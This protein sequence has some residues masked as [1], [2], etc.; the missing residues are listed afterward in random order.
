MRTLTIACCLLYAVVADA[1]RPI[2]HEDLWLMQRVGPPVVSP[3][4]R[5]VVFAVTAPAYDEAQQHVDLW[6]VPSD[7]SRPPRQLTFTQ[8]PE[9]GIVFSPDSRMI[10]FSAQRAGDAAPQIYLLDLEQGGEARRLT[11]RSTGARSPRFSPDGRRIAYLTLSYP[12]AKTDADNQR[13]AE[14]RKARKYNARVYTGF[15]IR[16]W[17]RWLDDRQL[18]LVVQELDA[19]EGRDLLAGTALVRSPG[20]GGRQTETGEELDY[21]WVDDRTLVFAATTNRHT[22]A[23]AFT[24]TDLYRVALAGGEPVRLTG[25]GGDVSADAYG[26]PLLAPDGR[27]LLAL[28]TPRT[29]RVY[30]ATRIA[31]WTWP[32]LEARATIAAPEGLSVN[33]FVVGPDGRSLW[34]TAEHAGMEKLYRARIGQGSAEPVFEQERGNYTN[35][36]IATAART[37]ILIANYDSATEPA[38]VVRLD[39]AQGGHRWLSNFNSERIAELDLAPVEHFWFESTRGARIHNL[40][41][42]P[43]RFDPERRYPLFVLIHG[44]PH[45]MWRDTFF[46]R[47]NYHLLARADFVL[48]LTNYTGSTGFGEAFAQG[49]QG[50]PFRGPAEE[51]DQAVDAALAQFPF[52]DRERHCA[53]GASYGGHLANWL[54]GTTTRYRCL[55]S[56]A[57]LVNAEAQWG[58]S[59]TIYGREVN[60]GGPPWEQGPVWREQNPIRLA[61][62]FRT[63]TL[64]TIGELDFRVP[65]NNA[66]EYWSA[67]QRMRVESRLIVFP[68][69]NHWILK[70]ENSRY[71]Y[72]EVDAWLRR[73]LLPP[74]PAAAAESSGSGR[75]S[76]HSAY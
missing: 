37:P 63:P 56:H 8:A 75:M 2:T 70:G 55:V 72:G 58:T 9:S 50:D 3:D 15:P 49:I 21:T 12:D 52:I 65:L 30:N 14:E 4:G 71:F 25:P 57:G 68:D 61:A 22:A 54:Q 13:I 36:S 40:L 45:I 11:Q 19:G 31:V 17:D 16:N 47:W 46:L 53:G 10:A 48:L 33:A 60:A 39:P 1:R 44:G 7:G 38:E 69:E 67:L 18:R 28:H 23:Y 74:D 5:R 64:V 6:L 66:L 59:D 35:L 34:F 76:A 62:N 29:D 27:H 41:V 43:A 51:I 73:W 24:H 42:R 20:Y 26:R 32:G